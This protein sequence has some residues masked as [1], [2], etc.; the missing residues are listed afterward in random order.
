[1]AVLIYLVH[2]IHGSTA[3]IFRTQYPWPYEV[4]GPKIS[5]KINCP[6]GN[7]LLKSLKKLFIQQRISYLSEKTN[8]L[9]LRKVHENVKR[10]SLDVLLYGI[11]NM[12]LYILY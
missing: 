11:T 3:L 5:K 9:F 12:P 7:N 2:Y 1:M 6:N 10:F 4:Q 8:F